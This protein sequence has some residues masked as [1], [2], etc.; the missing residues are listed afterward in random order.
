MMRN[1][2]QAIAIPTFEP[3]TWKWRVYVPPGR[4]FSL[5]SIIRPVSDSN[6][7]TGGNSCGP[8][9]AGEHL[10]TIALRKNESKE[11]QWQ[12]IVRCGG[13][14]CGPGLEGENAKW[15]EMPSNFAANAAGQ[16]HLAIVEPGK[17]L[18]MLRYRSFPRTQTGGPLTGVGDG[19]LVWIR[20]D[21]PGKP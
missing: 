5:H 4:Q 10:M 1:K 8:I 6:L 15:I 20:D 21:G 13:I 3:M 17:P 2:L 18:E 19:I 14:E 7:P 16:K 12:W 11:N 9:P